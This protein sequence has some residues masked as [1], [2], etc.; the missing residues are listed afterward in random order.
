[1]EYEL[2]SMNYVVCG[3]EYYKPSIQGSLPTEAAV[4][5]YTELAISFDL[6]KYF[7]YYFDICDQVCKNQPYP[8]ELHLVRYSTIFPVLEEI[9]SFCKL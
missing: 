7:N 5:P 1:M 8:R 2:C 9:L 6:C 4:N 3:M